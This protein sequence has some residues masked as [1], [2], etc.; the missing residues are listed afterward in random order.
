MISMERQLI[1]DLHQYFEQKENP[2]PD[3][4]HLLVSL[5]DEL[6]H[7]PILSL[8]REDLESRGFDVSEVTDSEMVELAKKLN[9]DSCEQLLWRSMTIIAEDDLKI[10]RYICP[11]CGEKA[12]AYNSYDKTLHCTSCQNT[13]KKEEPTGRYVLVQY[14]AD[15][16]F[17]ENLEVGYPCFNSEDNGARYVPEHFYRQHTGKEP[18]AN[19]LF[20]PV[21]WPESQSY[22]DL[23]PKSIA[24]LCEPIEADVQ[25]LEDFGTSSVW[26]PVCL[27]KK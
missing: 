17:Y 15:A 26:V 10:P 2:T 5:T 16:S 20:Q 23:K 13:W 3:E 14:P 9:D 8:S 12:S 1:E 24:A 11:Q 6:P 7:F 27:I 19:T 21:Q 18:A 25:S 4:N 22:F